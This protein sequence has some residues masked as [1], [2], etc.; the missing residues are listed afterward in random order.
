MRIII[1]KPL[2]LPDRWIPICT[3][4]DAEKASAIIESILKFSDDNPLTL[5]LECY[6]DLP[7]SLINPEQCPDFHPDNP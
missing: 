1:S 4:E 3:A 7:V 6:R 5:K 2:E